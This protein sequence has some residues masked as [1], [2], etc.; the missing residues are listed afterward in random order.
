MS[1]RAHAVRRTAARFQAAQFA[2]GGALRVSAVH[3]NATWRASAAPR[4]A[5]LP[6]KAFNLADGF[7]WTARNQLARNSCIAFVTVACFELA[8]ALAQKKR[9]ASPARLSAGFLYAAIR[10]NPPA[11]LPEGWASGGVGFID[12]YHAFSAFGLCPIALCPDDVPPLWPLPPDALS[13]A[14][15]D[16]P[17]K[18]YPPVSHQP[19]DAPTGLDDIEIARK[20]NIII[21]D[22]LARNRPVGISFPKYATGQYSTNWEDAGQS[23]G[24]L[25]F[26]GD[27]DIDGHLGGHAV[28]VT[29]FE[30]SAD[31]AAEGG[32]FI[33]RDSAGVSFPRHRLLGITGDGYGRVSLRDMRLHFWDV[34][35]LRPLS[36]KLP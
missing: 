30:P 3:H 24:T 27:A 11:T 29:G 9:P 6:K 14:S 16:I 4:I 33:F 8:R 23:D 22:E 15:K 19:G 20:L 12:A 5:H 25:H 36:E 32:Y 26:P 35:L 17:R 28:C 10:Q 18:L 7:D 2:A 13:A 34:L 31:A 1:H 21:L